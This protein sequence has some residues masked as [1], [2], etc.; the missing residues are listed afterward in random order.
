MATVAPR[1][2]GCASS[3]VKRK[4]DLSGYVENWKPENGMLWIEKDHLHNRGMVLILISLVFIAVGVVSTVHFHLNMM[5]CSAQIIGIEKKIDKSS[6]KRQLLN[7]ELA[8]LRRTVRIE[9]LARQQ[10]A[11]V[12]PQADQ[13]R[14]VRPQRK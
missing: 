12:D 11:M 7:A 5:E 6:K 1:A 13:V 9:R 14:I 8:Y 4:N 10:L 2:P 3:N